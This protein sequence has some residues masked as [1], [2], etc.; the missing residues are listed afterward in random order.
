MDFL[1]KTRCCFRGLWEELGGGE[2]NMLISLEKN[3][4][5]RERREHGEGIGLAPR[6]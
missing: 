4:Y 3:H 6:L 5:Q 1:N 2:R